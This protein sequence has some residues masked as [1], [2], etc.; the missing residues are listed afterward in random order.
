MSLQ[1]ISFV[2]L[3]DEQNIPL[4]EVSPHEADPWGSGMTMRCCLGGLPH[5]KMDTCTSLLYKYKSN[6]GQFAC[7]LIITA[8]KWILIFHQNLC[9]P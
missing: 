6:D 1:F 3:D 9:L 8:I 5:G 2:V 4:I 7:I